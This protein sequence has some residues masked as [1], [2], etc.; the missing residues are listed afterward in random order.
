MGADNFNDP[1][2]T[3]PHPSGA[4]TNRNHK[5]ETPVSSRDTPIFQI[6]NSIWLCNLRLNNECRY[7]L[8]YPWIVATA[9]GIVLACLLVVTSSGQCFI[10]KSKLFDTNATITLSLAKFFGSFGLNDF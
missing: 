10:C 7:R 8:I 5:Q 2:L 4:C 1:Q 3:S 6:S 9:I